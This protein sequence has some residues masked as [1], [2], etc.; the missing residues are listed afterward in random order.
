MIDRKINERAEKRESPRG[1]RKIRL[2]L[3]ATCL[4]T[5]TGR[6][7]HLRLSCQSRSLKRWDEG[8]GELR[9]RISGLFGQNFCCYFPSDFS[10]LHQFHHPH[11][12]WFVGMLTFAFV[13]TA[14][15]LFQKLVT[16]FCC[17]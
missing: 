11:P 10:L 4:H 7:M 3:H 5:G 12:Y 15:S 8:F 17:V 2:A 14:S 6:H 1:R 16:V 13:L 9:S